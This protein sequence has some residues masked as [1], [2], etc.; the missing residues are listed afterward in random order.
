MLAALQ[1]RYQLQTKSVENLVRPV[2]YCGAHLAMNIVDVSERVVE[3]LILSK[4]F[5]S[6]FSPTHYTFKIA[7]E[8]KLKDNVQLRIKQIA[9][10]GSSRKQSPIFKKSFFSMRHISTTLG[11]LIN[12]IWGIWDKKNHYMSKKLLFAAYCVQAARQELT[13]LNFYVDK[14]NSPDTT[15]HV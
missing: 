11:V 3:V 9:C 1:V 7:Q 15:I 10:Q 8:L 14:F 12:K 5:A 4:E 6:G 13:S 2:H